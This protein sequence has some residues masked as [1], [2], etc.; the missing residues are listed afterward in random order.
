MTPPTVSWASLPHSKPTEQSNGIGSSVEVSSPSVLAFLLPSYLKLLTRYAI[1]HFMPSVFSYSS[2][3]SP[4]YGAF[5]LSWLLWCL[6]LKTWS[7][8]QSGER[9]CG[10]G[11]FVFLGLDYS[12]QQNLFQ[13]HPL[14]C[15]V[16]ISFFFT[17]GQYS[18]AY[19]HHISITHSYVEEHLSVFILLF[20]FPGLCAQGS[21]EHS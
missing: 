14:S 15:T 20:L 3:N 1:P 8:N 4:T 5:I 19:V 11:I 9:T 6:Y 16:H 12:T 18:I 10:H 7:Q 17:V 13:I 21:H 2:P